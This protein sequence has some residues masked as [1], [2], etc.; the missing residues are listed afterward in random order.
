MAKNTYTQDAQMQYQRASRYRS[1]GL[2]ADIE[3]QTINLKPD[4]TLSRQLETS[5]DSSAAVLD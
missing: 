5:Q 4:R 2:P 1:C 3:N